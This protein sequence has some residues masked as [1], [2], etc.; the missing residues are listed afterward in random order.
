MGGK[1]ERGSG[2]VLNAYQPA[3]EWGWDIPDL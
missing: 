3:W 1:S 2:G